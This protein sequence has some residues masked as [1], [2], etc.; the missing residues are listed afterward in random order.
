MANIEWKFYLF[1][2]IRSLPY[3]FVCRL[4]EH[5]AHSQGC[6]FD[7]IIGNMHILALSNM[8]RSSLAFFDKDPGIIYRLDVVKP[9][10][11]FQSFYYQNLSFVVHS[12]NIGFVVNVLIGF[13]YFF[14]SRN[15]YRSTISSILFISS[16]DVAQIFMA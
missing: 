3:I 14:P 10:N 2:R 15:L 11:M 9:S 12:P 7:Q 6:L 8:A 1:A 5:F 13:V 4:A 16:I